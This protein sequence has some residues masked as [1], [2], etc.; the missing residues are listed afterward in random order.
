MR[1]ASLAF[2]LTL[3]AAPLAHA[4]SVCNG[5]SSLCSRL[6]SNVTFLG[7]HDSYAVGN[8]VADNQDKDV[9]AQLKDG[10]R[11]LQVQ[12]HNT[13]SDGIHLCHTSCSLV[14][15]GTLQSYLTKVATW[16]QSN[17]N[18]VISIVIVNSDNLPPTSYVSAFQSSGLSPYVYSPPSAS[19]SLYSW[20]TL[21]QLIDAKTNVVVFMDYNADFQQVPWI[22]DEF[23]NM[24]EDAYNVVDQSFACSV[25]RT[26]GSAAS[27]MMMINHFLD[28]TYTFGNTQFWVPDKTKLN[29]TNAVSGYGSI[30]AHVTNCYQIWGR[31]PNHILLDFY[32]SGGSAPFQYVASLNSVA[33]PTN[34]VTPG[35]GVYATPTSVGGQGSAT[36]SGQ[37]A[38][39]SASRLS[40][41]ESRTSLGGMGAW[42]TGA[43]GA[44]GVLV[45]GFVL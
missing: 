28:T 45:G 12:A 11:T 18:E 24:W 37:G 1:V 36:G 35:S 43:V 3:V 42:L 8:S 9:S 21:G 4:A 33:A 16:V 41:A 29:Q 23:S 15:G 26:S 22:I 30:G 40:G 14:D 31:N 20:P 13:S 34:T 5:A 7:T 6:Y 27:Q 44:F 32:D 10:I 39:I 38:V 17:P 25:N 2:G 19:L